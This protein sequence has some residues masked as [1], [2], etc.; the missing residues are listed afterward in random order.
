MKES[1]RVWAIAGNGYH[2]LSLSK[3]GSE[4]R[5]SRILYAENI[6]EPMEEDEKRH[7]TII[8]SSRKVVQ[9]SK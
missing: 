4:E 7:L 8:T 2:L 1:K 5:K 6:F 9:D 3:I